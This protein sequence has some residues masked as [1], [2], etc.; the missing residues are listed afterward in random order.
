MYFD[1]TKKVVR[2]ACRPFIGLDAC[3]L[4]QK[5]DGILLIV[6]GIDPNEYLPI[7]FGVVE[8]EIKDSWR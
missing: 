1:G 4:K 7:A 2:L 8:T 5:Y 3:H 6:V